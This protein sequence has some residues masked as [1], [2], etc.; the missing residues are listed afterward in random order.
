MGGIYVELFYG[1]LVSA[2]MMREWAL[3]LLKWMPQTEGGEM[4]VDVLIDYALGAYRTT[5]PSAPVAAAA[6]AHKRESLLLD[7]RRPDGDEKFYVLGFPVGQGNE[8]DPDNGIS[9]IAVPLS[10]SMECCEMM[11][12]LLESWAP[13]RAFSAPTMFA[14]ASKA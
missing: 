14:F 3:S 1:I 10:P 7:V 4:R 12:R 2:T 13:F 9:F 11:G 8:V 6:S 5:H